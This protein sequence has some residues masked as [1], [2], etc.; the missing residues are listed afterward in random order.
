MGKNSQ[1][2]T[3]AEIQ[4]QQ[5][6]SIKDRKLHRRREQLARDRERNQRQQL[7]QARAFYQRSERFTRDFNGHSD[8]VV[9]LT[10]LSN[11]I[12]SAL[13]P[14]KMLPTLP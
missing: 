6:Q 9:K 14:E 3:R 2:T 8:A 4:R 11:S 1:A 7:L 10:Q 5:N 12:I 13:N